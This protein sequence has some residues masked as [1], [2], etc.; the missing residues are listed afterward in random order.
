[1]CEPIE[2]MQQVADLCIVGERLPADVSVWL[3]RSLRAYLD[4]QAETLNEAFGIQ[5]PRGG[6][7]WRHAACIAR[8]DKALRALADENFQNMRI[9]AKAR[10]VLELTNRYAATAWRLDRNKFEM[11]Q[12][13]RNRP[14]RWLWIAF[15]SGATMPVGSRQLISILSD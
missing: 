15:K 9:T 10:T 13:Y 8:R 6:V 14:T 1:M 3:G 7:D 5:N 12:S 11:P 2:N 4:K